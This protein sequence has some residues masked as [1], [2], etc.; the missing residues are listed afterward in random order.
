MAD[1]SVRLKSLNGGIGRGQGAGRMQSPPQRASNEAPHVGPGYLSPASQGRA[2]GGRVP[3]SRCLGARAST[4][5]RCVFACRNS[6]GVGRN[7]GSAATPPVSLW[8]LST[9]HPPRS[10][11]SPSFRPHSFTPSLPRSSPSSSILF[12]ALLSFSVHHAPSL[13]DPV[14]QSFW[15]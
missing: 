15:T 14:I 6:T 5:I 4:L 10:P 8:L 13:R 2:R 11:F 1:A 3:G 7:R 9:H 12:R